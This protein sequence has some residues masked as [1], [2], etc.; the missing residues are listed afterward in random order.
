MPGVFL[1]ITKQYYSRSVYYK[2]KLLCFY[3]EHVVPNN[4][5][6]KHQLISSLQL[7]LKEQM[8]IIV[9]STSTVIASQNNYCHSSLRTVHKIRIVERCSH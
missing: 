7:T 6:S 5:I 2:H 8:F 9:T 4:K 3:I 1:D